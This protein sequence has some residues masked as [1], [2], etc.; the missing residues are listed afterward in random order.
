MVLKLERASEIPRGLVKMQIAGQHPQ[1]F[2]F[3]RSGRGPAWCFPNEIPVEADLPSLLTS[4]GTPLRETLGL[5]LSSLHWGFSSCGRT[6][7]RI[8][9]EWGLLIR[10]ID[11]WGTS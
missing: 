8:T 5:A 3:S 10:N 11:Y 2:S 4:L 9:W 1:S 7:I 6:Y